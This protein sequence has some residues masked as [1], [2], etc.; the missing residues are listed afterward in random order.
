MMEGRRMAKNQIVYWHTLPIDHRKTLIF[1]SVPSVC[2]GMIPDRHNTA[3]RKR[4]TL[5]MRRDDSSTG[6]QT[7]SDT[8]VPSVCGGMILQRTTPPTAR[9]GTLRMRRDD[10]MSAEIIDQEIKYPPYAEG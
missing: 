9:A 3:E 10:S 7:G 6:T 8:T 4:R 1:L 5:R 2:G